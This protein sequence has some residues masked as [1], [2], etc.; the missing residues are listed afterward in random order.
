MI[1][2]QDLST[3]F[4]LWT[5]ESS[6]RLPAILDKG[7]VH[8]YRD[9][10]V[11]V[12]RIEPVGDGHADTFALQFAIDPRHSFFF[13]HPLDHVP[14]LMMV[15]AARQGI[16][17][18]CHLFYG[19]PLGAVFILQGL[20]IDFTTFAELD[21][22]LFGLCFVSDKKYKGD[23]LTEMFCEGRF[24]QNGKNI[25]GMSGRWLIYERRVAERMRNVARLA[26]RPGAS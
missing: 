15:E 7:L 13:E 4:Q 26:A 9:E 23:L 14:G 10:N 18:L 2:I 5:D 21:Q 12:S 6:A 22:P 16:T 3:P 11:F 8:K 20:N 1:A 24:I 25:G 19:V 17:A